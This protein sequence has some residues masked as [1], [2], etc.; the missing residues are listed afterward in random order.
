MVPWVDQ[1]VW[2]R[3]SKDWI[4]KNFRKILVFCSTKKE[5]ENVTSQLKRNLPYLEP[6]VVHHGSLSRQ[7]RE[8][9]EEVLRKAGTGICVATTTLEVGI[10]IGDVDAVCLDGP[11]HSVSSLLQRIGRGS[12]RNEVIQGYG[13]YRGAVSEALFE[14]LVEL[15]QNLE[16]E[17]RETP[18]DLSV[19]VQQIF[20]YIHQKRRIGT[21][22]K[23]LC[24]LFR[25]FGIPEQTILSILNNLSERGY[26]LRN[27][28]NLY[29]IGERTQR[30]I[31]HGSVH[32]NIPDQYQDEL[33]V[34]NHS[35][36]EVLG[37]IEKVIPQFILAGRY[38]EVAYILKR[39]VYVREIKV[40]SGLEY[41]KAPFDGH[42]RLY[43]DFFTGSKVKTHMF[44][45]YLEDYEIPF[46][47]KDDFFLVFH[48]LGLL[49]GEILRVALERTRNL[50]IRNVE[51]LF[52]VIE[53]TNELAIHR[54]GKIS[55]EDLLSVLRL[56]TKGL[57]QLIQLGRFFYLLPNDIQWAEFLRRIRLQEFHKFISRIKFKRVHEDFMRRFI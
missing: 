19:V 23:S 49:Y 1:R 15:A 52:F 53:G 20:S 12:R 16:L 27:E 44:Q 50:K 36:N 37:H 57:S 11:P 46:L 25:P 41:K 14:I 5:A 56:S 42:L 29:F 51:G 6:I 33:E 39:R 35:T 40:P 28:S 2:E 4:G 17:E 55:M 22:L 10:D 47:K 32:T 48:F 13:L 43:A 7:K 30:L 3:L 8:E 45:G 21:S 34:V 24:R 26:V 54:M 31:D 18:F 9:N 38:W